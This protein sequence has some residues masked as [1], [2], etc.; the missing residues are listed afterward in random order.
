MRGGGGG[1][2]REI[3]IKKTKKKGRKD[4]DSDEESQTTS[5]GMSFYFG[6]CLL[7]ET[8]LYHLL[9]IIS[10]FP[11]MLVRSGKI[12]KNMRILFS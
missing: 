3:K 11:T 1:N 10:N 9:F 7:I 5:T 8:C 12:S 6:H 2:A 4:A